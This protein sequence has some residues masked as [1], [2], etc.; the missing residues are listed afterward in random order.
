MAVKLRILQVNHADTGGGAETISRL[1]HQGFSRRGHESTL[2][3]A[4]KRSNLEG[5]VRIDNDR[6]RGA[7]ARACLRAAQPLAHFRKTVRGADRLYTLLTGPLADSRR[8]RSRSRGEEDFDFPATAYLPD[9]AAESP[10]V[11]HLHNLH[12]N[13]FDLREL[14]TLSRRFPTFITLHDAWL[15]SGHCAHSLDCDRWRTGC[16]D[17]PDLTLYPSVAKDATAFNHQRKAGLLSRTRMYVATPSHWLMDRVKASMVAPA[18]IESRVIP[19]GVDLSVFQPADQKAARASLNIPPDARVV[20]FVAAEAAGNPYKDY[21]TLKN[22]IDRVAAALPAAE[23]LFVVLGDSGRS[24]SSTF[25]F[26]PFEADAQAVARYYQA[27]D[28]YV[29]A[30]KADTFPNTILEAMACGTPVVATAVGGIPE[31]IAD[32]HDGFLVAPGASVEMSEAILKLLQDEAIRRSLGANA[33][34]KA[35]MEFGA[36]RMVEQYLNWYLE[37]VPRW[38]NVVQPHSREQI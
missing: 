35:R 9:L 16:G 8:Y 34:K 23:I 31:Q 32:G 22:A 36:E 5:V 7:W 27:A 11:L 18:I 15:L 28:I 17:C 19:N 25:R 10:D 4:V 37:V 20:L 30:A 24:S 29:H 38:G 12:G 26:V 21:A 3:V 6:R 2:A 13:Y 1:L 14:P 33:A